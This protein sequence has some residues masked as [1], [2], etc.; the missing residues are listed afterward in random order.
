MRP[1]GLLAG[2]SGEH[3]DPMLKPSPDDVAEL[4]R[5]AEVALNRDEPQHTEIS[6]EPILMVPGVTSNVRI[7]KLIPDEWRPN[8]TEMI[9][10]AVRQG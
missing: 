1:T 2:L 5:D 7:P 8:L 10:K 6:G 3:E 4:M 9:L